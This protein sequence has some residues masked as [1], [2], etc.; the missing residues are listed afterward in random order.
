MIESLFPNGVLQYAIGGLMVGAGVAVI[1]LATAITPGASTFLESTLSY[2][3][4][5][6]R[7]QKYESSR[8]WRVLFTLGIIG[9][10]AVYASIFQEG[11]WT[12]RVGIGRLFIGG[13][14]VGIGTRIGKG[15]T[16]GHGIN[17]VGSISKTSL[18][19]VA[20]FVTVAITTAM[21]AQ[22]MGVTP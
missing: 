2:F 12:T 9:G 18:L 3:S 1:Y 10:A 13:I 17:G 21:I 7:F 22:A 6:E 19:N 15:C 8:D 14:L 4:K 5:I 16:S 11:I 20:T